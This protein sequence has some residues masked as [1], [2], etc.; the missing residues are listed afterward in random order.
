MDDLPERRTEE[1][2]GSVGDPENRLVLFTT[3]CEAASI[4]S[5][6]VYI[7]D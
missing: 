4:D 5:W 2:R 3:N 1:W 6:Y 7:F